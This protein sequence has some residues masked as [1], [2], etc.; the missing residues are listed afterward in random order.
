MYMLLVNFL[1]NTSRDETSQDLLTRHNLSII[2]HGVS[3]GLL[4]P[5]GK[6]LDIWIRNTVM[7]K[8]TI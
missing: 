5:L 6:Y 3:K 4:I 8:S 1:L 7:S 2:G